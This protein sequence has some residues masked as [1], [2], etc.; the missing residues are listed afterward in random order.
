MP[1][2]L[3]WV[4]LCFRVFIFIFSV[5][6]L[7]LAGHLRHMGGS[8]S[9]IN[10]GIA[11]ATATLVLCVFFPVVWLFL[12]SVY[13][14]IPLIILDFICFALDLS[15]SAAVTNDKNEYCAALGHCSEIKATEA[16]VYMMWI[17]LLFTMI[18]E[19]YEWIAKG[20]SGGTSS[21]FGGF[22]SGTY[23]KGG[24]G[25]AGLGST[26]VP[27]AAKEETQA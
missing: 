22:G 14:V 23:P 7:G 5:I 26:S 1:S 12:D 27:A 24:V 4:N 19:V 13:N 17:L 18:L 16:F 8:I 20:A 9:R 15:D 10:L 25:A 6:A 3:H 2:T 21:S 11:G